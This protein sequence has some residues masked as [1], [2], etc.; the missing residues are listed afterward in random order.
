MFQA[1][2]VEKI[3]ALMSCSIIF[4]LSKIVSFIRQCEKIL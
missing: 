4:F 1:K 3:K 2:F